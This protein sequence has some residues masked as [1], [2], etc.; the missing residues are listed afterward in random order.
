MPLVTRPYNGAS[1]PIACCLFL[2]VNPSL[3]PT[4]VS[5]ALVF[6]LTKR[7]CA[8]YAVATSISGCS[9]LNWAM[10][11]R[12]R[13]AAMSM[14]AISCA[15]SI[16]KF[17]RVKGWPSDRLGHATAVMRQ[18]PAS[19]FLRPVVGPL[20]QP[21]RRPSLFP[22]LLHGSLR[23]LEVPDLD[24]ALVSLMDLP[25]H[26]CCPRLDIAA[27]SSLDDSMPTIAGPSG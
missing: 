19:P 17:L 5:P 2:L 15:V 20:P 12:F 9:S 7:R 4:N 6:E 27:R 16:F 13:S 23:R 3:Y 18:A 14:S 1:R 24:S 21:S 11:V 25:V 8:S 10:P 26:S 22:R